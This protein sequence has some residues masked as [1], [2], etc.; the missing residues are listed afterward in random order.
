MKLSE[1]T[2]R[3][4]HLLLVARDRALKE[5]FPSFIA[6]S[7]ATV[8]PGTR[9]LPNWHIDLIAE[10][11][12][13]VGRSEITRLVINMPPRALKSICVSVAWPAWLLGHDP[14][15]RI[16]CASYA[17]GLALRH[18]LDTRLILGEPW[19]QRLFPETRIVPGENEKKKL[20][21]TKRGF[22]FATSV[23]GTA[24]GEGGDVLIVDDPLHPL[25]AMSAVQ[26]E[27][28]NQWFDQ[29]FSTRLNNKN[30]G[31][32]VLVMQRLHPEDVSGHL[33]AQGGWERLCL[34]ALAES[35]TV[36]DFGRVN[37]VRQAG[38]ALH[39]AR[40]SAEKVEKMRAQLGSFGFAAQYQQ[41]P[42]AQ[43]GNMIE[44]AWLGRYREMP[45]QP[46][47]ITQSWD[48]AIKAGAGNDASACITVGEAEGRH[49]VL[50]VLVL[51]AEY[52]ALKRA[53]AAQAA[54]F[55]PEA[56]LVEDKASGQSLLQDLRRETNLPLIARLPKQ[57]K[58]SRVA[59]V[60]AMIEAGKLLL[61]AQA[62]WLAAFEEELLSF[63]SAPHD[64]Q[65]DALTQ[66]LLWV[67]EKSSAGVRLRGV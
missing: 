25:Q 14:A 24:T 22:R 65:V 53:V 47:R 43:T 7:F 18:S 62:H 63:P 55:S 19:Y 57:D 3:Q 4:R 46:M 1:L 36:I 11:L 15:C 21:T 34:P 26:R 20:V 44:A 58:L 45:E 41:R 61:P 31:R 66:Y 2:P 27:R 42:L 28:A 9:Y 60:S 37:Y 39:P 56:I 5:H 32:I 8:N 35:Q 40:E 16:M 48:T 51:K 12:E 23:G 10:Y 49:Y 50:D 54:R 67:R 17:S 6:A 29:T 64:D 13:A 30:T 33:L 38:E 59:A 52:P